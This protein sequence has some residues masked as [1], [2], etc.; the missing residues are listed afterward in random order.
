[1]ISS[2]A[3]TATCSLPTRRSDCRSFGDDPRKELAWH[4]VFGVLGG[5]LALLTSDLSG[6]NGIAFSP[7]EKFLYVGNWDD[8]RKIVM[9][10][11]VPPMA[12]LPTAA[13]S[14]T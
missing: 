13:C 11:D 2:T 7:D 9:R 14:S 8:K 5:K 3:P 10:Y 4:G 6:P 12:R 1:M